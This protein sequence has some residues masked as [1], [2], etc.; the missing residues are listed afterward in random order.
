[1]LKIF[2]IWNVFHHTHIGRGIVKDKFCKNDTFN[3]YRVNNFYSYRIATVE[4]KKICNEILYFYLIDYT[5]L[6]KINYVPPKKLTGRKITHGF[7]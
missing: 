3:I 7:C 1:M 5:W 6:Q 4:M 2:S